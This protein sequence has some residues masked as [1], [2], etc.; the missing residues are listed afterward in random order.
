MSESS[1]IIQCPHCNEYIMINRKD[2][3]CKIF[4]H[5]IYIENCEQIDPHMNKEE[6]DRL[7]V[8]KKIYGCSK[9]FKLIERDESIIIEKCDYI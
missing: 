4:R 1:V 8:E 5:G 9:P 7:I 2:F 6:C 3:N